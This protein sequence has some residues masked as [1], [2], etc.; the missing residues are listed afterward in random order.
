ML[1]AI[2]NAFKIKEIRN[3]ILFTLG[4]LALYRLGANI[5]VPGVDPSKIFEQV[6]AGLL[7]MMDL[8]SGGALSNFAV[9]SLGIMPYITATIILQL[10]QVVIPKLEQMAKEG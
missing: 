4:I 7:G 5:P 8:F 3:R 1:R 2:S 6:E 10:L 9:F